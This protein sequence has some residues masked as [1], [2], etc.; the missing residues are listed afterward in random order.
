MN[1]D[2]I[3]TFDTTLERED[4]KKFLRFTTFRSSMKTFLS[5]VVVAAVSTALIAFLLRRHT[6]TTILFIFLFMLLLSF[7]L[8]LLKLDHQVKL[9][10][11][12]TPS[13]PFRK[14]QT[15]TLYKSYMTATNRMNDGI[16]TVYYDELYEIFE[17]AD[18]LI[19]YFDKEL[20]TPIRKHDIPVEQYESLCTFLKDTLGHRYKAV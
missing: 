14:Q 2:I 8:L 10:F 20:V 7:S 15:I 18:F 5:F 3:F 17:T 12:D 9:L 4:Y 1:E 19:C 11:S 13:N 16:T 6:I